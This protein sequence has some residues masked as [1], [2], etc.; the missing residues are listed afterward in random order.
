MPPKIQETPAGPTTDHAPQRK[1]A[2][3]D[4]LAHGRAG[5]AARQPHAQ[6]PT[7]R[8]HTLRDH[9][10]HRAQIPIHTVTLPPSKVERIAV[11]F[12]PRHHLSVAPRDA[13]CALLVSSHTRT[14][15]SA[16]SRRPCE[17][18]QHGRQPRACNGGRPGG[19]LCAIC[20]LGHAWFQL[21]FRQTRT[22]RPFR[23]GQESAHFI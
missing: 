4:C 10:P 3:P 11:P 18:R 8:P 5:G 1:P 21:W 19:R 20:P 6:P 17:N 12:T 22:L 23:T 7:Q 9:E 15:S 16:R 2:T 14:G 13:R